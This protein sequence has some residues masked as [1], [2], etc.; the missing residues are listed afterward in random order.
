MC[1]TEGFAPRTA[2]ATTTAPPLWIREGANIY[3]K[4]KAKPGKVAMNGHL[5]CEPVLHLLDGTHAW[6]ISA[7]Y[8]LDP[9]TNPQS[10]RTLNQNPQNPQS[11]P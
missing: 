6:T 8:V 10:I 9:L 4:N 1:G 7:S 5:L 2:P 11:K 3:I